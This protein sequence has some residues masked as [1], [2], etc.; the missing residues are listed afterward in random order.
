MKIRGA[1]AEFDASPRFLP[2]DEP[3]AA[4]VRAQVARSIEPASFLRPSV[5]A[6]ASLTSLCSENPA[7]MRGVAGPLRVSVPMRHQG[8]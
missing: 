2:A 7:S 3:D 8:A 6:A 5:S 1:E 4:Q